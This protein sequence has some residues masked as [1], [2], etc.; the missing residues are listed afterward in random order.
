MTR[1]SISGQGN[2]FPVDIRY[3]KDEPT[4]PI[5]PGFFPGDKLLAS[6]KL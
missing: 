5:R 6:V 4:H 2:G 3:A 1:H